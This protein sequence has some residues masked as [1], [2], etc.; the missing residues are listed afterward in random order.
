M[1]SIRSLKVADTVSDDNVRGGVSRVTASCFV[2]IIAQSAA[3]SGAFALRYHDSVDEDADILGLGCYT[4]SPNSY[5]AVA[6]IRP[7]AST[8]QRSLANGLP[9][10]L[11]I[12]QSATRVGGKGPKLAAGTL[13]TECRLS[14]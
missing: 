13:P 14:A 3:T 11:A 5:N 4:P 6:T 12:N 9:L 10:S 8:N 2:M 7:V 1:F